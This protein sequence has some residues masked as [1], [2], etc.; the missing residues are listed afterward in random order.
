MKYSRDS[1]AVSPHISL[2]GSPSNQEESLLRL[3]DVIARVGLKKTAIYDRMKVGKFPRSRSLGP[4][5]TVWAK[6]EIDRWVGEVASQ[7]TDVE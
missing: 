4:R 7:S 5:C 1:K 3:P 2:G 6:S